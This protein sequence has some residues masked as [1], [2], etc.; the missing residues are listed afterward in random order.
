M[1]KRLYIEMDAD[2]METIENF[3]KTMMDT[4]FGLAKKQVVDAK[5]LE[6]SNKRLK[7]SVDKIENGYRLVM[8]IDLS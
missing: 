2:D 5:F 3:K 7:I 6:E 1:F 8:D 4:T